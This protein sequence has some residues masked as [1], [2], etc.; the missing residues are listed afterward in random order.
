MSRTTRLC[1]TKRLGWL[2][3]S[4]RGAARRRDGPLPRI[5][6]RAVSERA[7]AFGE[8]FVAGLSLS[9]QVCSTAEEDSAAAEHL[10][11]R[12]GEECDEA[13]CG[14]SKA[15]ALLPY[16]RHLPTRLGIAQGYFD[17]GCVVMWRARQHGDA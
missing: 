2:L 7:A 3:N 1:A 17:Y 6:G 16:R 9:V 8:K 12:G 11:S 10:G 13:F 14:W 4:V 15:A 5:C